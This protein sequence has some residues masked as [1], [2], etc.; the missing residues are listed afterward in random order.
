M[1]ERSGEVIRA[2]VA[3]D[4]GNWSESYAILSEL[5][6]TGELSPEGLEMLSTTSF[7]LGRVDDMVSALEMAHH[8]YLENG[9]IL[10]AVRT[11]IW[12]SNHLAS[13]DK[14][15]LASGWMDRAERLMEPVREERPERGYMLMPR[16]F[17]CI[18]AKQYQE[19][20]ELAGQAESIGRRLGDSELVALAMQIHGRALVS[21]GKAQEGLRLF[22][23]V[24][25]SV[26]ADDLSPMVTGL[27]Y[28]SVIEGCYEIGD[29]HR[30][31]EW[32]TALSAW[33]DAQP[34]LVAFTG[35]CL[36]HRA[37]IMQL[38]GVWPEAMQ[39]A[40][41][42]HERKARGLIA[43]QA[44]YQQAEIHRLQGQFAR[45]EEAYLQ[46]S[47]SGGDPQPGLARL[48]LAEGNPDAA[49]ASLERALAEA[50]DWTKRLAILP[51]VVDV[52]VAVGNL[53]A[54]RRASDELSEIAGRIKVDLHR[55]RS[56]FARGAVDLADGDPA[57]A[58]PS[59]RSALAVWQALEVPHEI[60]RT[61][62]ALGRAFGALGDDDT[63]RLEFHAARAAFIE[64]GATPELDEVEALVGPARPLP[65]HLTPRELEVLRLLSSGS[66]N[67]AIAERLTVS[68]RTVD[69][70]VSNIFAKLGVSTRSA[71]T[72]HAFRH[73]LT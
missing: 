22:D 51:A 11:A 39:Q 43:A 71:A 50:G 62:V 26:T 34:D 8:G 54:A 10:P 64:L 9:E 66:T 32:T 55:A 6:R 2:R 37:E 68:E 36:A 67:R 21:Q 31:A 69:R 16:I 59:L 40:A 24:M 61:E 15:A 41:K 52:M 14:F 38:Q 56:M 20:A 18:A 49:A 19:A 63:A 17:R 35:Q 58:I 57:A 5:S 48:R 23:E 25:V 44:Y 30:A 7:M 72:A 27:V 33:C 46:V 60:A 70:H 42:A 45:A 29:I 47:A 1:T 28:C 53:L 3:F 73:H 13:R 65:H 4:G 12:L